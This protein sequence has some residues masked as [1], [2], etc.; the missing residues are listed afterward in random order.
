MRKSMFAL[1]ALGCL[2][3][4]A[5]ELNGQPGG[6]KRGPMGFGG[7]G[8]FPGG[9]GPMASAPAKPTTWEYRVLTRSSLAQLG[10]DNL[11]AGLNDLGA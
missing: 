7:G 1:A 4:V 9:F 10:K 5:V 11:E 8:G 2:L 6:G 3:W